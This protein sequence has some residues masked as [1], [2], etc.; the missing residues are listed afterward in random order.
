VGGTDSPIRMERNTHYWNEDV[1]RC[2]TFRYIASPC[3]ERARDQQKRDRQSLRFSAMNKN[4]STRALSLQ[5]LLRLM[6]YV[7]A[8]RMAIRSRYAFAAY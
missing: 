6:L 2:T 8:V 3:V 1:T 4:D 7:Q 5:L